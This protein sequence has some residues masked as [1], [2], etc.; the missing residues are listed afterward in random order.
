MGFILLRLV[1]SIQEGIIV[2]PMNV[3]GASMDAETFKRYGSSTSLIQVMLALLMAAA[4]A[5][6]GWILIKLGNDTSGPTL[7]S[8]W[9]PI[10][11]WQLYEYIDQVQY[12]VN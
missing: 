10:L 2:Q 7:Y 12:Q 3:F 9:F 4:A 6:G 11:S 1:R 8:L 5:V